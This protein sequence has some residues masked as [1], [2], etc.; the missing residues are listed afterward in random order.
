MY[1]LLTLAV[2]V[3]INSIKRSLE[4][5]QRK[6]ANRHI[7]SPP[8]DGWIIGHLNTLNKAREN[9]AVLDTVVGWRKDLGKNYCIFVNDHMKMMTHDPVILKELATS[10]DMYTKVSGLP[11]RAIRGQKLIG[12]ASILS[13]NGKNWGIKRKAMSYFFSKSNMTALFPQCKEHLDRQILIMWKEKVGEK[14]S[15]VDFH[16]MMAVTYIHFMQSL[17]MDDPLEPQK[18]ADMTF[19]ILNEISVK[20]SKTMISYKKITEMKA[21]SVIEIVKELRQNSLDV[22]KKTSSDMRSDQLPVDKQS[23][24]AHLIDASIMTGK[25][26]KLLKHSQ[27]FDKVVDDIVT[28]CLV[29]D[30]LVKQTCTLFMILEK[31]P[32][33][34]ERMF[35]E[36]REVEV[37]SNRDLR[38]LKFTEKCILEGMRMAPALLRGQRVSSQ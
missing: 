38:D 26:S 5:V 19:R 23:M 9:N 24:V 4:S 3:T 7:P 31:Y 37:E 27:A 25:A 32:K 6:W 34:Q 11:N 15:V 21:Q 30:N 22:V 33:I 29:T 20:E 10:I 35:K 18:V 28:V 36:L 8:L 2:L 13:G 16:D 17:G 12:T 1:L 14:G